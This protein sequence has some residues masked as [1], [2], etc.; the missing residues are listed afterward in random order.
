VNAAQLLEVYRKTHPR[1]EPS[2][3]T[4]E[5]PDERHGATKKAK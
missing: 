4:R 2:P 5:E 1:A 3:Q